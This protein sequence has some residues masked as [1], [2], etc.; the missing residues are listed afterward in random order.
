VVGGW[1]LVVGGWWLVVGG[2]WL[3]AGGWWLVVGG[4]WLVVGGWWLVAGGWWLGRLFLVSML[5]AELTDAVSSSLGVR[6]R[7]AGPTGVAQSLCVAN[8]YG[9]GVD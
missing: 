5:F 4:W 8:V 3:V 6:G 7:T 2:W 1:W 9:C